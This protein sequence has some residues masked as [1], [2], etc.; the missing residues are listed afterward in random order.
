MSALLLEKNGRISSSKWTKHIK[1]KYFLIK[2]YYDAGEIDVKFCPTN[3]MWADV[4]TKLLQGQKFRD[5]R[6][7]LQNC[8]WD[9]DDDTE[10]QLS[11]EPQNVCLIARVCWWTCQIENQT[12]NQAVKPTTSHKPQMRV[13]SHMGTNTS[14]MDPR[15]IPQGILERTPQR[16]PQR[17][18]VR[19]IPCLKERYVRGIPCPKDPTNTQ[20]VIGTD[21][22]SAGI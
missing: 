12:K 18:Q 11:M 7:F 13:T 9:Y 6:A 5:M 3:E 19:R 22:R 17:Q 15:W 8:P 1:V 20:D 21:Q 10:F 16:I 4:L 2:D 14:L